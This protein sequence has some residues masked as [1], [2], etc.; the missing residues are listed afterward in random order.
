MGVIKPSGVENIIY[1][2][3]QGQFCVCEQRQK[4]SEAGREG[5]QR[6]TKTKRGKVKINEG[7]NVCAVYSYVSEFAV[8]R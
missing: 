1:Q 4:D 7:E 6:A 5:R 3:T 2:L 8:N